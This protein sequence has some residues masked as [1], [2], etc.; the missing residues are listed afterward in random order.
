MQVRI[1]EVSAAPLNK[2]LEMLA[3]ALFKDL[4]EHNSFILEKLFEWYAI[5]IA[6]GAENW[7]KIPP[8]SP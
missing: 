1:G 3:K 2:N 5:M 6:F 4:E 8:K 7:A